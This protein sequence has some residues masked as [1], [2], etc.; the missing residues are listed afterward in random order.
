ML[1]TAAH[2]FRNVLYGAYDGQVSDVDSVF[3]GGILVWTRYFI[4]T[5]GN[6]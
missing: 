2:R 1:Y 5:H 4:F 6:S 3:S